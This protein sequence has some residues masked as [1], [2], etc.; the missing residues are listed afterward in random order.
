MIYDLTVNGSKIV[1]GTKFDCAFE[2]VLERYKLSDKYTV[3]E[4][5]T[6][7]YDKKY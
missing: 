1:M 7:N 3:A 5:I 4:N 6:V 2:W